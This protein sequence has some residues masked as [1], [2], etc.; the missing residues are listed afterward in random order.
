MKSEHSKTIWIFVEHDG[1]E[2]RHY[3]GTAVRPEDIQRL[4]EE[5]DSLG[6][7]TALTC[8]CGGRVMANIVEI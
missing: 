2:H 7:G 5:A 3:A 1:R 4:I 6:E 8:T